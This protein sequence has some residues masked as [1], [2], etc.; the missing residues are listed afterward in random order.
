[1]CPGQVGSSDPILSSSPPPRVGN[2]SSSPPPPPTPPSSPP[3]STGDHRIGPEIPE[4]DWHPFKSRLHCQLVLL[5]HVCRSCPM[6]LNNLS[7]MPSSFILLKY[8][9]G[10]SSQAT[11]FTDWNGVNDTNRLKTNWLKLTDWKWA[12][13]FLQKDF[14]TPHQKCAKLRNTGLPE[15]WCIISVQNYK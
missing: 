4:E 2:P 12:G 1:M 8:F 14:W 7:N 3:S 5:Y 10:V 15:N 6:I 9:L 13:I 11:Y